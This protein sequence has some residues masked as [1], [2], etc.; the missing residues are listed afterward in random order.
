MDPDECL[1][2]IRKLTMLIGVATDP[3]DFVGYAADLA[4]H[5]EAL[6][7]WIANGGFLPKAWTAAGR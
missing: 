7:E 5:V 4:E 2:E 3:N 6:D 1:K